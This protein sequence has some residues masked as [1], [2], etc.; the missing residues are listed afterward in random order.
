MGEDIDRGFAGFFYRAPSRNSGSSPLRLTRFSFTADINA[1]NPQKIGEELSGNLGISVF[2]PQMKKTGPLGINFSGFVKGLS[3]FEKAGGA[4]ELG[5]SPRNYQFNSKLGYTAYA[6]K[7]E[8]WDFSLSAAV[9]FRNG[10]LSLKAASP[11][12]PE[13][14]VWTV[15]WRLEKR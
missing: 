14:W 4:F 7:D 15:S 12:F 13:K 8:I 3:T 1:V 2:W 5:F 10:R 9:R 11:N 6:K